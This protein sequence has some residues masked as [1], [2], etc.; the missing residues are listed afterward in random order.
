MQSNL[1][2]GDH[3]GCLDGGS[4]VAK[5]NRILI[6]I[7]MMAHQD[8][9]IVDCNAATAYKCLRNFIS[10]IDSRIRRTIACIRFHRGCGGPNESST[11]CDGPDYFQKAGTSF[12][13]LFFTVAPAVHPI[14]EVHDTESL[15]DSMA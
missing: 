14:I 11:L 2:A 3:L 1:N 4:G 7:G 9:L 15:T 12:F 10:G 6:Q 5:V 8:M 13:I